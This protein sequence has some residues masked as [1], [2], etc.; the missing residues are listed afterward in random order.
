[1]LM[2]EDHPHHALFC[3]V[4]AAAQCPVGGWSQLPLHTNQLWSKQMGAG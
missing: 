1:M 4:T 2:K 3:H